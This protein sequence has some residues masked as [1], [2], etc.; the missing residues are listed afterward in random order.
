MRLKMCPRKP[1]VLERATK[2]K[3][4]ANGYGYREG[5]ELILNTSTRIAVLEVILQLL[6]FCP[7]D[8]TV[9][10]YK[11][12]CVGAWLRRRIFITTKGHLFLPW[13]C[14]QQCVV[15]VNLL[16][17]KE[18]S[19]TPSLEE[20]YNVQRGQQESV[21]SGSHDPPNPMTP[22]NPLCQCCYGRE[23]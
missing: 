13:C 14:K 18:L 20:G 1:K 12:Y 3:N 9:A 11:L 23:G 15:V 19:F 6:V 5:G 7:L 2:F 21:A 10:L 17:L 16:H 8:G 22:P 4:V